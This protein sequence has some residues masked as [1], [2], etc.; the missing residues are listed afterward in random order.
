MR[1]RPRKI[2][3]IGDMSSG[4]TNLIAAYSRDRFTPL[5][6]PTILH[7]YQT[8]ARVSNESIDLVVIEISGRD[9]FKPLR[10]CAYHKMDAAVICYA[11]NNAQCFE[12]IKEFWVPE[13]R[14]YA[15]KVPFVLVGTKKDI[16]EHARDELEEMLRSAVEDDKDGSMAAR[17]R[18][19][20]SF[21]EEFVS[22]DRGRRMA[23]SV[24]AEGHIECSSLY[25]DRTRDVF[26]TVT[27]VALKK[28]RRVRA[29]N[30]HLGA[31]C[32]IL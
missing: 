16:K 5:Y 31:M 23:S 13:L 27:M 24:G 17:L 29:D 28:T 15:P 11:V 25:R 20:V 10:R 12:R 4:K 14:K 32:N 26:E 2:I 1:R 18:A 7:C 19:E 6:T 9:D 21:N 30:R 22:E 3:V 8:D